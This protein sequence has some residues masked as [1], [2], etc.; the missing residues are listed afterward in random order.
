[1]GDFNGLGGWLGRGYICFCFHQHVSE[2]VSVHD[3][4][5]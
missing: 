2:G 4:V 3:L 5:A 1:M